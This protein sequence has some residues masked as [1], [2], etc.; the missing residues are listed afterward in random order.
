MKYLHIIL[1]SGEQRTC[2]PIS[3]SD[4]NLSDGQG[5]LVDLS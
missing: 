2:V 1:R 5:I 3:C 4:Q